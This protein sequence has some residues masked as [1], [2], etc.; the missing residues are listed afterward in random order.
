M[1][2]LNISE[3]DGTNNARLYVYEAGA[4]I[5]K[6]LY[7]DENLTQLTANPLRSNSQ[8]KFDACYVIEGLY[9]IVVTDERGDIIEERDNVPVGSAMTK[10]ELLQFSSIIELLEDQYLSY[11]RDLG[12]YEIQEGDFLFADGRRYVYRIAAENATDHHIETAGGVKLYVKKTTEGYWPVVAFGAVGDGSTDDSEAFTKAFSAA[13]PG[14]T[15]IVE[16]PPVAYIVDNV[17]CPERVSLV[18]PGFTRYYNVYSSSD[19]KG[20][21]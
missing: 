20:L 6:A 1:G 11:T 15:V 16:K 10:A 5:L 14:D 12:R 19:L 4:D 7:S 13:I 3:I 21:R 18:S 17:D 9:R 8:G 2:L